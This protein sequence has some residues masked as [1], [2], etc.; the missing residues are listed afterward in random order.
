MGR[1]RACCLLPTGTRGLGQRAKHLRQQLLIDLR[2]RLGRVAKL[3]DDRLPPPRT[4]AF[5]GFVFC[6]DY[7]TMFAATDAWIAGPRRMAD[8]PAAPSRSY[9]KLEEAFLVGGRSPKTGDTAVDLG[10]APGGWSYSAARRGASVLAI[11]NGPLKG[12]AASH[13]AILHRREDAFRYQPPERSTGCSATWWSIPG[14]SSTCSAAGV[15]T[16][17]AASSLP[18]SNSGKP[19][20]CG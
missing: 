3:A 8:D 4:E 6:R 19:T 15:P 7:E 13:P 16:A 20:R 10:A 5:G 11:D 1:G 18:I 12:G 2:K 9:L 17:G 14:R